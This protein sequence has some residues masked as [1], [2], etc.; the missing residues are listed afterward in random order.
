M[1]IGSNF[2]KIPIGNKI[3]TLNFRDWDID[4]VDIDDLLS[5]DYSNIMGELL[6]FPPILN[7]IGLFRAEAEENMN[8]VKLDLAILEAKIQ[9]EKRIS[10]TKVVSEKVKSPTKDEVENACKLDPRYSKQTRQF[11]ASQK[12]YNYMESLYIAAKDK[13]KKLDSIFNKSVVPKEFE[14]ELLEKAVNGVK[15]KL[16][17]KLYGTKAD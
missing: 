6:T 5:I 17:S 9:E 1:E 3:A 8:R 11:F 13:S 15:V 4:E 7:K 14:L 12:A 16:H 2:I 10:L